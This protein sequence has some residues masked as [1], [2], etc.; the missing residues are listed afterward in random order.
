M[1]QLSKRHKFVI[2]SF[3][4]F[5]DCFTILTI[6]FNNEYQMITK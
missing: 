4:M 2:A 3:L 5:W 6:I 1:K